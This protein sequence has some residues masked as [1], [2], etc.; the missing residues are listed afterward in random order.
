MGEEEKS[1]AD[2]FESVKDRTGSRIFAEIVS[3]VQQFSWSRL[4]N[5][6]GWASSPRVEPQ[7]VLCG[8]LAGPS[9]PERFRSGEL[10][11]AVLA[12]NP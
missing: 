5:E 7:F 1:A 2:R 10:V 11:L 3:P 6:A 12:N 8:G 9:I 4:H